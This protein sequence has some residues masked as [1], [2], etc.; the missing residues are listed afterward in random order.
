MEASGRKGL[1]LP[2][3][4]GRDSGS[5]TCEGDAPIPGWLEKGSFKRVRG[6]TD[7][8]GL[9]WHGTPQP[10][11]R[12]GCAAGGREEF[13]RVCVPRDQEQDKDPPLRAQSSS[14]AVQ[15]HAF[16]HP[17]KNNDTRSHRDGAWVLG[18]RQSSVDFHRESSRAVSSQSG[19]WMSKTF[20]KK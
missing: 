1:A 3:K 12:R 8:Q 13:E 7:C 20:R 10:G 15:L 6:T 16:N 19:M 2:W 4:A 17:I 9:A 14:R 11:L 5:S 18:R